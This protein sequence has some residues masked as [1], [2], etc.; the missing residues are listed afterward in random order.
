[1]QESHKLVGRC[2][3]LDRAGA[4]RKPTAESRQFILHRCRAGAQLTADLWYT[5]WLRSA[6]MPK[7]Y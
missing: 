2:Y 4:F 6:T 5:A 7:H 3:E 1:V